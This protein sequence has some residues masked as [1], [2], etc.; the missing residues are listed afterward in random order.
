[1][2]KTVSF[3]IATKETGNESQLCGK[4]TDTEKGI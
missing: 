3:N 1:M 2:R 4:N